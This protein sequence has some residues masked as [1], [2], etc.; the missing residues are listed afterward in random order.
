MN[1]HEQIPKGIYFGTDTGN[2]YNETTKEGQGQAFYDKWIARKDEFPQKKTE[3]IPIQEFA[4]KSPEN[5][6]IIADIMKGLKDGTLV[7]S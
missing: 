7:L 4:A 6:R 3:G 5:A 1:Q 2:F